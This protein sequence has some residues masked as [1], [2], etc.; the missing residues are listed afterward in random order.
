MPK[1]Y[2]VLYPRPYQSAQGEQ[3]HWMHIGK[4]FEAK[5]GGFDVIL[6]VLPP[7]DQNGK[8]YRVLIREELPERAQERQQRGGARYAAA[9]QHRERG[10]QGGYGPQRGGQE[11]VPMPGDDG[12]DIPF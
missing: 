1:Q 9:A 3:T 6:Y 4:A 12:D 7:P 8:G 2:E 11:Q 5:S 10:P